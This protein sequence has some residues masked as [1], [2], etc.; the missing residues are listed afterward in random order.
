M[1]TADKEYLFTAVPYNSFILTKGEGTWVYDEQGRKYLDLNAGQFCLCFG[2]NDPGLQQVVLSQ[3]KKIYHTNTATLTPEVL[4]AARDM[5]G[6]TGGELTKT[7]FLSTGSE[8]NECALRYARFATGKAGVIAFKNGYHGLTLGSQHL[9]MGG[10]W[11]QP[12]D[13]RYN[14]YLEDFDVQSLRS[15]IERILQAKNGNVCAV[16]VEPV[17]GVG[18]V[19]LPSKEFFRRLREICTE[20]GLLLIFD[21]CQTGFGRT[22]EWFAYQRLGVEPDILVCAKSMGGGMPVSSVTFNK[23]LAQRLEGKYI[24]FSSHQNDPLACAVVSYIIDTMKKNRC[25]E[26]N[27]EMGDYLLAELKKLAA[28]HPLL[29]EPRGMGLMLGFDFPDEALAADPGLTRRFLTRLQEEGVLLQAIRRG[30]TFR[31]SPSFIITREEIDFLISKLDK[32]LAELEGA[33]R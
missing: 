15:A 8:A 16:M 32:V 27:R 20:K 19:L 30:K 6:I 14:G 21:E 5:A 9:T 23:R 24:H 25:L 7:I 12:R 26:H 11:A 3:M 29:R 10:I 2:H 17:L 13:E 33:P 1:P 28:A 4:Q 18:G 31:L 22:G